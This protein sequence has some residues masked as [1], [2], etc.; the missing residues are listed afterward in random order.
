[1]MINI[2]EYAGSLYNGVA[3][4][5]KISFFDMVILLFTLNIFYIMNSSNGYLYIYYFR[6]TDPAACNYIIYLLF[7]LWFK[8]ILC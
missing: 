4:A 3:S 2:F 6:H 1:M 5:A 7:R 8:F